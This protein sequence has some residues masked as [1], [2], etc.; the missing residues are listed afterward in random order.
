MRGK[1]STLQIYGVFM[2]GLLFL[3]AVFPSTC[4]A[5]GSEKQ[6]DEVWKETF[7]PPRENFTPETGQK[8]FDLSK[9][10]LNNPILSVETPGK[11]PK[12][13]YGSLRIWKDVYKSPDYFSRMVTIEQDAERLFRNKPSVKIKIAPSEE[14]VYLELGQEISMKNRDLKG[15]KIRLSFYAYRENPPTG[16]E[17][18]ITGIMFDREKAVIGTTVDIHPNIMPGKWLYFSQEG[19]V[20]PETE[21]FKFSLRFVSGGNDTVWLS[22]F[23][24]EEIQ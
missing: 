17:F 2:T 18:F 4:F 14:D 3:T 8:L 19:V 5:G 7:R 6:S 22:G 9:S 12:S 16:K 1:I 24:L 21:I 13:W 15:K 11:P 10:I 20:K 23:L